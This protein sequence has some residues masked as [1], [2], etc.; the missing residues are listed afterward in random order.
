MSYEIKGNWDWGRSIDLHTLK[1]VP[2]E[3]DN[4]GNVVKWDTTRSEIGELVYQLKY[5]QDKSVVSK[6]VDLVLNQIHFQNIDNL[7]LIPAPPSKLDREFQPVFLIVEELAKRLNV[8]YYLDLLKKENS[9][10]LK[11]ED[12]VEKRI[13]ILQNSIKI[14]KNYDIVNKRILVI[15]DLYRSGVT[16]SVV[17][18][19]LKNLKVKAVYVLTMT[20]TRTKR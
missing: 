14:N 15:D 16:L 10:E 9:E 18:D 8:P 2:I 17:S 20:K 11:N 4:Y 6:I 5:K 13:K 12:D 3:M 1:S 7:I 19:I